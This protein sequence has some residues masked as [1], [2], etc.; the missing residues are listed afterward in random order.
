MNNSIPTKYFRY[1]VISLFI[2]AVLGTLMRYKIAFSFPY[3]DQKNLLHAHSYFA[4]S[5]WISHFFILR[6]GIH[7]P[8]VY[9]DQEV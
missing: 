9:H 1:S 4:F 5:G 3:F 8:K 7:H 6:I 2:V